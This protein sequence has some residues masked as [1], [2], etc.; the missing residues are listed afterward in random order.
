VQVLLVNVTVL[1][2]AAGASADR[3]ATTVAIARTVRAIKCRSLIESLLP[4]F[5][6]PGPRWSITPVGRL[7]TGAS[8]SYIIV[9]AAQANSTNALKYSAGRYRPTLSELG[10]IGL[11]VGKPT[12]SKITFPPGGAY[13]QH[14]QSNPGPIQN[15]DVVEVVLVKAAYATVVHYRWVG[16]SLLAS[17]DRACG[18]SARC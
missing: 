6:P 3:A 13:V 10:C 8:A 14:Y 7:S 16:D 2:N 12:S 9:W 18:D 1:L 5:R 15:G 11:I 17:G 4:K